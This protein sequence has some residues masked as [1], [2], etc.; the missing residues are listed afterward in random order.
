[1]EWNEEMKRKRGGEKD[2]NEKI[3]GGECKRRRRMIKH[4]GKRKC[5]MKNLKRMRKRKRGEEN[6]MEVRATMETA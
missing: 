6:M 4:G 1:M 2:C 5:V 3:P